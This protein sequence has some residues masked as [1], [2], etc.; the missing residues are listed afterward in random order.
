M[1]VYHSQVHQAAATT[2]QDHTTDKEAFLAEL[3]SV[4]CA[5]QNHPDAAKDSSTW[6][7]S[8]KQ[9]QNGMELHQENSRTLSTSNAETTC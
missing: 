6:L 4:N 9:C 3:L 8:L 5:L 2:R 1:E 7:T